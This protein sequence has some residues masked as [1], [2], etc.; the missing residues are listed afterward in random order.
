MGPPT[1][2]PNWFRFNRLAF[3][4]NVLRASKML[5][6][7]NSKS[8]PRNWLEPDFVTRLIWPKAA[9]PRSAVYELVWTLNS[10]MAS[11]EG[12]IGML[13]KWRALL[14]AP[15]RVKLFWLSRPPIAMPEP[16]LPVA[17]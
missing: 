6:R 14:L 15:S 5:L 12:R 13:P 7:Q 2:P 17:D 10:W 16:L 8:E 3:G 4:R 9:W 11:M 1:A